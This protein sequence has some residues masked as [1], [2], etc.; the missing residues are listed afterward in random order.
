MNTEQIS[1]FVPTHDELFQ[2]A[3]HW[4][5]KA[6]GD[7]WFIFCGQCFGSSDLRSI[8]ADW[9]RVAEI[10]AILGRERTELAVEEAY[11]EESQ[12]GVRSSWIVFRYGTSGEKAAYQELGGQFFDEFD[13]GVAELLASRVVKRVF[14]DGVPKQQESLLKEELT[15]YATKLRSFRKSGCGVIEVFGIYFPPEI[16]PLV[17]S[18]VADDPE[19]P[20]DNAFSGTLTIEQGKAFLAVL[21][22]ASEKGEDALKALVTNNDRDA[23]R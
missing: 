16:K 12:V 6:I 10:E 1:R 21:E 20:Q 3:K 14:R 15:R 7:E 5:K 18:V 13:G 4:V 8:D 9:E 2:L 17:L 11:R 23:A 19:H 22:T